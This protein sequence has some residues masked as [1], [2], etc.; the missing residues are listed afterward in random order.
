[1]AYRPP[2]SFDRPTAESVRRTRRAMAWVIPLLIVPQGTAIFRHSASVSEQALMTIAWACVILIILWWLLGL[3]LRWL[4]KEEQAKLNDEWDQAVRDDAARWGLAV[5]AIFGCAMLIGRFWIPFD[6][7]VGVYSLVNGSLIVA[8]ARS[9][10]LNG[11][12]PDE[13]E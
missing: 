8:I 11:S 7:G 12:E 1:M 3:P 10:W 13:D 2:T 9:A 6:G 5:M 4:P